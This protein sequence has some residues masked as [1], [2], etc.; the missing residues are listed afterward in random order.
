M[1]PPSEDQGISQE[2]ECSA[3]FLLGVFNLLCDPEEGG[4]TLF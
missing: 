2:G 3:C 4:S 1:L